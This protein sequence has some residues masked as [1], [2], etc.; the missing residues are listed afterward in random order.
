MS[1]DFAFSADDLLFREQVRTFLAAKL[2]PGV[3]QA[4]RR[5]GATFVTREVA[6]QWQGILNDQ[7]WLA[8]NW[9]EA[10]GGTGWSPMQRFIF[11]R[12]CALADAPRLIPMGLRYVGPVIFTF[13]SAWQQQTF[14]PRIL[15]GEHYW[16]QGF[17]EPGA[18]SDLASLQ[19]RAERRNGAYLVNGSKIWTT[20]A[21]W[22]DWIFCIVRTEPGAKAQAGISF[23]LIDMKS[24]GIRVD[25]IVTIGGDH[26]VNQVFFDDVEV[27]LE[28]LVGAEGKGWEYAKFLLQLERGG[29][30]SSGMIRRE[31]EHLK[32]RC[33]A[34]SSSAVRHR[35]A[36]LEI[37]LEAL[38][39][40]ELRV[41]SSMAAGQLPGKESSVLK[42]VSTDLEQD[43]AQ[44]AM[45]IPGY[46]ALG[47]ADPDAGDGMGE[48]DATCMPRYLNSRAASIYGGSNEIQRSIIAGQV[49]GLR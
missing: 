21:H 5:N 42:L 27:P 1:L 26:E 37:R 44:A 40:T 16:A 22:A 34:A 47:G 33:G 36:R 14:L 13:G 48:F 18:G 32:A 46:R 4:T 43:L 29:A 28:N 12:E 49:L 3:R 30:S 24:P 19:C 39:M 20:H 17:S 15:S 10:F 23:L 35:L 2:P 11:E 41:M 38:E 6:L 9:P 7:G 45:E 31:L 25:P 8:Y